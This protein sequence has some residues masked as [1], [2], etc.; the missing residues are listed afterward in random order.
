MSPHSN[1]SG[2]TSLWGDTVVL[3]RLWLLVV[4]KGRIFWHLEEYICTIGWAEPCGVITQWVQDW[5]W[6]TLAFGILKNNLLVVQ[7]KLNQSVTASNLMD[8]SRPRFYNWIYPESKIPEGLDVSERKYY[9]NLPD[10]LG[11][12]DILCCSTGLY[13]GYI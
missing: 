4:P 10:Y 8:L 6:F 1:V 2:V 11:P 9:L 5:I 3:W 12:F 7:K 13:I